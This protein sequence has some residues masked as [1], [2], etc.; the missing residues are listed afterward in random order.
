MRTWRTFSRLIEGSRHIALWSLGL[1]VAQ[2]LALVPIALLV[3][4]AFDEAI[5]SEDSGQLILLGAGILGLY[6]LSLALGLLGRYVVL[7]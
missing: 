6:V 5:P 2:S 4:N 3:R 1:S 7:R